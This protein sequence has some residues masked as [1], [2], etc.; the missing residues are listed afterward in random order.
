MSSKLKRNLIIIA[1]FFITAIIILIYII[2]NRTFYND[3]TTNGSTAGNLYNGGLFCERN[4]K[5]FFSNFND[6]GALYKMDLECNHV[7][8]I[9]DDKPCFINAD[10]H[11]VYYSRINYTK[12]SA[13][14][15]VFIFYNRGIYRIDH[16]GSN[17]TLLYK[18]PS[19]LLSLYGNSVY[20]QHYYKQTGTTF[21]RV[22]I[23]AKNEEKI[24]NE[25][26]LPASFYNGYLYYAGVTED[27]F[28]HAMNVDSKQD[29]V[30]YD[31]NCYMPVAT[32]EGI[33]YISLDDNYALCRINYDG[34]NQTKLVDRF[35]STYNISPDGNTIYYQV[36]SGDQN[37]ICKLDLSTMITDTIIDGNYKNIHVT[38]NY[39]FFR[40][41]N[42]ANTY[43]Y[44]P[45][46][47]ELKTFHAPVIE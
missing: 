42:E 47:G 23:D 7:E 18:E 46:T 37:R 21:Y 45:L 35:C 38:S 2:N 43:A 33:Y 17:L 39:I 12:E 44:Q 13:P 5:V 36:D 22:G 8:K 1:L 40:D 34:S 28:I 15:S 3:A 31:G 32:K 19:G 26:L 30:I 29:Q 4:G 27:H 10:D 6:D 9:S 24:N 20:Y 41:F 14:Q 11:Y 25:P 16:D